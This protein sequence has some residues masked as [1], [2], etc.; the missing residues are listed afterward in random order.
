[1][2]RHLPQSRG[3]RFACIAVVVLVF[4]AVIAAIV[5]GATSRKPQV[6]FGSF[7]Q[8]TGPWEVQRASSAPVAVQTLPSTVELLVTNRNRYAIEFKD[9]ET[10]VTTRDFT[11]MPTN[12]RSVEIA[13]GPWP[14]L[15]ERV[16][17]A[18]GGNAV[19][20][21]SRPIKIA[22]P[23]TNPSSA[24]V[25]ARGM[26]DCGV[27]VRMLPTALVQLAGSLS[28]TEASIEV[29][30][31]ARKIEGVLGVRV[32]KNPVWV[33]DMAATFLLCPDKSTPLE[34]VTQA[35]IEH[36]AGLLNDAWN[37]TRTA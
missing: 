11:T 25:L 20:A 21:V 18:G 14:V 29:T 26:I 22:W 24:R 35:N 2:K 30:V 33:T 16:M 7:R 13:N 36:L 15:P 19:N 23:L 10:S 1:M 3:K 8:T 6:V 31:K 34:K 28:S 37:T 32:A 9:L 4:A 12:S 17:V 27:N 5:L